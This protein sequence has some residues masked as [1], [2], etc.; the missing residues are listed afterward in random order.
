MSKF[1][2]Y[3]NTENVHVTYCAMHTWW[4]DEQIYILWCDE[5][6]LQIML[7]RIYI[8]IY[9]FPCTD[10]T[11]LS[12][13]FLHPNINTMVHW[14]PGW[15]G[16]DVS[17]GVKL[18]ERT[19]WGFPGQCHLRWSPGAWHLGTRPHPATTHRGIGKPIGKPREIA[20]LMVV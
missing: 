6:I 4:T 16:L 18:P 10:K 11:W 7:Y 14:C 9:T 1:C 15:S 17:P 20:G 12:C 8:Y 5:L 19:W 3:E 2:M 13:L